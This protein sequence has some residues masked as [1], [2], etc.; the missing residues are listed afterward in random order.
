MRVRQRLI[1]GLCFVCGVVALGLASPGAWG[2]AV[3]HYPYQTGQVRP[4]MVVPNGPSLFAPSVPALNDEA[5]VRTSAPAYEPIMPRV[6]VP[7]GTYTIQK[8]AH[9][10]SVARWT[11]TSLSDL[12][13]LN[14]TICTDDLLPAGTV[15]VLPKNGNW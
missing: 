9:L 13:A 1:E 12:I 10:R 2:Q 3:S 14:P 5:I 6:I 7:Q 11:K 4:M 8:G 15:I